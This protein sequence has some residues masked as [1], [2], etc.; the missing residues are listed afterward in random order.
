M[1]RTTTYLAQVSD[2]H[3]PATVALNNHHHVPLTEYILVAMADITVDKITEETGTLN[4]DLKQAIKP[5][6]QT[7]WAERDDYNCTNSDCNDP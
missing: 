6:V 2:G 3:N 7:D 5:R 4:H 1:V